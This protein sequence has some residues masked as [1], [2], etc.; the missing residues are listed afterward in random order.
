MLSLKIGRFESFFSKS[1]S[2]SSSRPSTSA[3]KKSKSGG[4]LALTPIDNPWLQVQL[5]EHEAE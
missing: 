2:S 4:G 1:G 5:E 3:S